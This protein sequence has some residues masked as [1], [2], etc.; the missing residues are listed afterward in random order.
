MGGV[1]GNGLH[2]CFFPVFM[3]ARNIP[4]TLPVCGS[5]IQVNLDLQ[6]DVESARSAV[7]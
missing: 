4:A 1:Y 7:F 5:K 2:E 6:Q 3:T